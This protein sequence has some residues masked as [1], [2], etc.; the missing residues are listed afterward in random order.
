M[1]GKRQES[2]FTSPQKKVAL[3][4]VGKVTRMDVGKKFPERR[5]E[6][7]FKAPDGTFAIGAE[8]LAPVKDISMGGLSVEYCGMDAKNASLSKLDIFYASNEFFLEGVSAQIMSEV[9]VLKESFLC[10]AVLRRLGF[11]F[12]RLSQTQKEH[13]NN[14]IQRYT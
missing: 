13:I 8:S 9:V 14:F 2:F 7:R 1:S 5:R 10:N 3:M 6:K 12:G 4:D 11:K